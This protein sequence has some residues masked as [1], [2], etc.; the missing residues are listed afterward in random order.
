MN[1]SLLYRAPGSDSVYDPF[2]N[3]VHISIDLDARSPEYLRIT[4]DNW[5][6]SLELVHEY[7]HFYQF[8]TTSFGFLNRMLA[9]AQVFLVLAFLDGYRSDKKRCKLPLT[10]SGSS[11]SL[12]SQVP[13]QMILRMIYVLE[14][15]RETIYG[16]R[17]FAASVSEA[18]SNETAIVMRALRNLYGFPQYILVDPPEG[19]FKLDR[20]VYRIDELLESHAHA[21][22]GLW[23]LQEARQRDFSTAIVHVIKEHLQK[24]T[25]GPYASFFRHIRKDGD[26]ERRLL[27][28][29]MLCDL[30]LNPPIFHYPGLSPETAILLLETYWC[31]AY[32]LLSLQS[33]AT[34]GLPELRNPGPEQ[35]FCFIDDLVSIPKG[36]DRE[37]FLPRASDLPQVQPVLDQALRLYNAE[38]MRPGLSLTWLDHIGS[39]FIAQKFRSVDPFPLA[40]L[41]HGNLDALTRSVGGPNVIGYFGGKY[42]HLMRLCTGLVHLALTQRE[43]MDQLSLMVFTEGL[44]DLDGVKRLLYMNRNEIQR[45]LGD[46]GFRKDSLDKLLSVYNLTLDAFD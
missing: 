26:V 28:H 35:G 24:L 37:W 32:R 39:Y 8:S 11:A 27:T 18:F 9:F 46:G 13:W 44:T 42:T 7:A 1:R 5:Q 22:A 29:C 30:A 43:I 25:V 34:E 41:N 17:P 19:V 15:F 10:K 36:C 38:G 21:L 20:E 45:T 23:L 40:A 16:Y 4:E 33:V 2:S 3:H 12:S 31:P 6:D 14:Q